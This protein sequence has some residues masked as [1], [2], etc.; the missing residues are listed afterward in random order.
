LSE[1]YQARDTKPG[2]TVAVKLLRGV[3]TARELDLTRV[4]ATLVHPNIA[5]TLDVFRPRG[6]LCLPMEWADGGRLEA[7]LD[8]RGTRRRISRVGTRVARPRPGRG[9]AKTNRSR[10]CQCLD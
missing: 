8:A 3:P 6:Q 7:L 10:R 5:R 2:Q 4:A 1:V 9:L